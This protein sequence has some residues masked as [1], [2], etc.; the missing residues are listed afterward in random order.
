MKKIMKLAEEDCKG[1]G[2]LGGVG[3]LVEVSPTT[4]GFSKSFSRRELKKEINT[5]AENSTAFHYVNKAHLYIAYT[6]IC[7]RKEMEK[8]VGEALQT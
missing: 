7:R 2:E 1:N 6:V 5:R 4:E 8:L 3:F